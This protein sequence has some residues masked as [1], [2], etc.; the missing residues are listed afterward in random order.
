MA[1]FLKSFELLKTFKANLM[2]NFNIKFQAFYS[3]AEKILAIRSF[4]QQFSSFGNF[5]ANF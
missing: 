1:K 4:L 2:G 5:K 3:F